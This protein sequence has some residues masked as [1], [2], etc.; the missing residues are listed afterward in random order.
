MFSKFVAKNVKKKHLEDQPPS[1][2][3]LQHPG[4][5]F[6]G[7]ENIP[8]DFLSMRI[9]G[10]VKLCLFCKIRQE[11]N[12]K[13]CKT[14]LFLQL[15]NTNLNYFSFICRWISCSGFRFWCD[16]RLFTCTG[17]R[18][19]SSRTAPE[20]GDRTQVDDSL[21]VWVFLRL[22]RCHCDNFYV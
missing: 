19:A 4:T 11:P 6:W 1:S 22:T 14:Q 15:R 3:F 18:S 12:S 17:H 13:T 7:K 2:Y 10:F 9:H 21:Q 8:I 20:A 5:S 16:V